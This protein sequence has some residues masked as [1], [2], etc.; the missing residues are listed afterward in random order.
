MPTTQVSM[1]SGSLYKQQKIK[2]KSRKPPDGFLSRKHILPQTGWF[3]QKFP[4][5]SSASKRIGKHHE[6]NARIVCRTRQPDERAGRG[7][8]VQP[9]LP[10]HCAEIC[11]AQSH[12]DDFGALVR[13]PFAGNVRRTPRN[14]LRFL[15]LSRSTQPSAISRARLARTGGAGALAVAA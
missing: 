14:D 1:L 11:Q 3:A 6:Q 13:Q 2:H 5:K 12:S 8:P 4:V 15:R 7:K 9:R 10:P